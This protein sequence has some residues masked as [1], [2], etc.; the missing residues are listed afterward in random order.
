MNHLRTL[1]FLAA[2][3]A[4]AP[5]SADAAF[6]RQKTEAAVTSSVART[7]S[8]IAVAPEAAP[9]SASLQAAKAVRE[10]RRFMH[11]LQNRLSAAAGKSQIVALL[12]TA[13]VIGIHRF[14][15]GYT[16]QGVV[17]L[18]TF[19]GFGIWTFIDAVRIAIGSLQPKD[20]S[21]D[22]GWSL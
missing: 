15:L 1:A 14:Y 19:G 20:D 10:N 2:L 9:S 4:A 13:L 3:G 17:Q 11:R 18:L 6:V 16:W 5:Q 8:H 22:N 7:Q 21:Y 12:L